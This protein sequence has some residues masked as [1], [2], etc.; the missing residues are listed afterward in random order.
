MSPWFPT[1]EQTHIV[2]KHIYHHIG[3]LYF[4]IQKNTIFTQFGCSKT[5]LIIFMYESKVDGAN[6]L[7]L[8]VHNITI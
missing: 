7:C 5:K 4:D 8:Q 1:Q 3:Y 2:Y 6:S